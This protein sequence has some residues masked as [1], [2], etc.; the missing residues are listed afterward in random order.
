MYAELFKCSAKTKEGTSLS[1]LDDLEV[2][3]KQDI[4]TGAEL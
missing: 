1:N 2:M 4:K 3:H